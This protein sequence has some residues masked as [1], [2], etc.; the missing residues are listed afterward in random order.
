MP[1]IVLAEDP[2]DGEEEVRRRLFVAGDEHL[3]SRNDRGE[4]D[5]KEEELPGAV[6]IEKG[7]TP[8]ILGGRDSPASSLLIFGDD[9]H[10]TMSSV[11]SVSPT[12]VTHLVSATAGVTLGGDKDPPFLRRVFLAESLSPS[13]S[14]PP[15]P[16]PAPG[17]INLHRLIDESNWKELKRTFEALQLTSSGSEYDVLERAMESTNSRGETPVH[18]LAWKAPTEIVLQA[19]DLKSVPALLSRGDRDL[20]TPVHLACANA[21]D[22]SEFAVVREMALLA[23]QALA[24]RNEH[25]DTR[26]LN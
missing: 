3:N 20:N 21:A 10:S 11:S 4:K 22:R 1:E 13:C 25:G 24:L 23:P 26:T 16:P 14:A 17:A 8:A 18:T 15:P 2:R 12:S 6:G 9:D 5:G 19:L 7:T